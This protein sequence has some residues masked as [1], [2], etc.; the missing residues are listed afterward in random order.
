VL[1]TRQ[2]Y[3]LEKYDSEKREDYRKHEFNNIKFYI[4]LHG[5]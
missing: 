4:N 2:R 5:E 3:E 1:V